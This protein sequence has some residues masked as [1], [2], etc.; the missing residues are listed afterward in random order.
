M[1]KKVLQNIKEKIVMNKNQQ[2]GANQA[3]TR[4]P[5]HQWKRKNLKNP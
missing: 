4:D 3:I 2:K 1:S 5:N